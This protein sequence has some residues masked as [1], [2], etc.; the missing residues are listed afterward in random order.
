VTVLDCPQRSDAWRLAR[1]GRL[2]ASRAHEVLAHGRSPMESLQRAQY[3]RQLVV[4]RLTGVPEE[5]AFSTR[6]MQRG[7][8]MEPIALDAYRAITRIDARTSGFVTHDEL[9]AGCSLDA[10]VGEF[11]GVVE[12]KVPNTATHLRYWIARRI[13]ARYRAQI[14]H[15]LWIT[16]ARWCDFVSFDDRVPVRMQLLVLRI[17]REELDIRGYEREAL[18]F[19]QEVDAIAAPLEALP[20]VEF[21]RRAPIDVARAV[22]SISH[23]VVD[24]RRQERPSLV[25]RRVGAWQ[26][27]LQVAS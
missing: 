3:R 23:Q 22:L 17:K 26:P 7:A 25:V 9:R 20:P 4:E 12:I 2:T 5:R 19:L 16:G 10:H 11:E 27:R 13:P 24:A 1:C 15:H 21:F 14:T 6:A 8:A 18:R